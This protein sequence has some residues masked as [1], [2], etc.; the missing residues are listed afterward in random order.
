VLL[1][2]GAALLV[3][4]LAR[5]A[6]WDLA[7]ELGDLLEGLEV[8]LDAVGGRDRRLVRVGAISS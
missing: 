7:V 8:R 6:F 3:L 4:L 1:P 2:L 5:A